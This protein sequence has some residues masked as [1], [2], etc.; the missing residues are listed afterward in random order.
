MVLD[1]RCFE[2]APKNNSQEV[3]SWIFSGL[4]VPIETRQHPFYSRSWLN[5][6]QKMSRFLQNVS[7]SPLVVV[8]FL[9]QWVSWCTKRSLLTRGGLY[10]TV[11]ARRPAATLIEQPSFYGVFYHSTLNFWYA[12]FPYLA[13]L[14][15]SVTAG[16]AE[17]CV[18]LDQL[19]RDFKTLLWIQC[20]DCKNQLMPQHRN[21]F[22]HL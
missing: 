20:V 8:D 17:P 12:L 5:A 11:S 15:V 6:W 19:S 3:V 9:Q 4:K 1:Q 14:M 22:V 16:R 21:Q 10:S 7:V 18:F 13:L 2:M